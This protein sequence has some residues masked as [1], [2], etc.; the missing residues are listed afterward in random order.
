MLNISFDPS[1]V[2]AIRLEPG[3]LSREYLAERSGGHPL[4]P[5]WYWC[6]LPPTMSDVFHVSHLSRPGRKYD[7][8]RT[9][10]FGVHTLVELADDRGGLN[11]V[12]DPSGLVVP[13]SLASNDAY[14]THL[15]QLPNPSDVYLGPL[16]PI[17][18]SVES[19]QPSPDTE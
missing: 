18:S 7:P 4:A 3:F 6:V 15:S 16:P 2:F 13:N 12:L 14:N 17:V 10:Q 11:W 1:V 5:V 8:T 19:E 9:V